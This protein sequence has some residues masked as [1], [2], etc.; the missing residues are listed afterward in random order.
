MHISNA[1]LRL[2]ESFEGFSSIPYWDPYGHLWTRGF[3]ETEGIGAASPMITRE[4]GQVNLKRLVE[5]RYEPAI[6]ALGVDL[7]Q[8]QWDALCSLVWNLGPG[9]LR[10]QLG[11]MLRHREYGA[12]AKAMLAYDHAGGVVLGGLQ[13]RR[14]DESALFSRPVDQ[15]VPEDERRW[16]REYD[17]LKGKSTPWAALRRR[18]LVRTMTARRKE[19]WRLAENH[20]PDGWRERNR[21]ARYHAL[22]ARTG[23]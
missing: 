6:R 13:R 1:G 19:I 10:G 15:Y 3:G 20:K 8:N 9:I 2:I 5:T 18:V 16:E 21:E 23:G 14:Q 22:A 11:T 12:F 7:N 17:A 4:Q